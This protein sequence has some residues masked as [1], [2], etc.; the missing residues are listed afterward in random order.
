M[1][2][3]GGKLK[4][5]KLATCKMKS[6]R[7]AMGVVRKS[8]FDTLKD[9][10]INS[11]ILDL[12]AGTGIHAIEALSR[13]AK[14]ITLID[15]DKNA[16]KLINKNLSLCNSTAQ[17]ILGKLPKSLNRLKNQS[18]DI[19][20]LD[21]PYGQSLFIEEVLALLAQKKLIKRNGFI[22][23]ESESKSNFVMPGEFTLYKEKRF[24]NTKITFLGYII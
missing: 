22:I 16:I 23:V 19:V 1:Y 13:G 18:F 15:S 20:F 17:I 9:L 21:P 12:C 24:G 2:I 10:V 6:I 3:L 7:P 4:G 5:K 11:E 14:K 8:I